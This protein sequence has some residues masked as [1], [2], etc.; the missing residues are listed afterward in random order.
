MLVGNVNMQKT[1]S[2]LATYEE[3]E[4]R[5]FV[6]YVSHKKGAFDSSNLPFFVN[7]SSQNKFNI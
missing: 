5:K 3:V 7:Y 6:I 4:S 2:I 1:D